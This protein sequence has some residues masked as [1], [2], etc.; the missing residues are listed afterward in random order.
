MSVRRPAVVLLVAAGLL[1][2]AACRRAEAAP[3]MASALEA[4]P[5]RLTGGQTVEVQ[6]AGRQPETGGCERL[7]DGQRLRI[8]DGGLTVSVPD[9]PP[10]LSGP[11]VRIVPHTKASYVVAPDGR[12]SA[13]LD[14]TLAAGDEAEVAGFVGVDLSRTSPVA[15]VRAVTW[16][17]RALDD[18][19]AYAA[20]LRGPRGPPDEPGAAWEA[21]AGTPDG[22]LLTARSTSTGVTDVHIGPSP[23][24]CAY[25][26]AVPG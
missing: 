22:R 2:T 7:P 5:L 20:V 6:L 16:L 9:A 23:D 13:W 15:A 17:A 8:R 3:T 24:P 1:A 11:T 25:R 10:A 21:A 19:G 14:R 12:A 4:V 18:A 26:T